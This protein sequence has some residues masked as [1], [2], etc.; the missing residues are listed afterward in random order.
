MLDVVP[1]TSDDLKKIDLR[2]WLESVES[3]WF[4][5]FMAGDRTAQAKQV[6]ERF[7]RLVESPGTSVY[8]AYE[9]QNLL[10]LAAFEILNW[11]TEYFG[12]PFARVAP[13]CAVSGLS[14]DELQSLYAS[15]L[16][17]AKG[18]SK[19]RNVRFLQRR[20]LSGRLEE[21]NA[22][23]DAGF[24]MVDNIVTM[25][26]DLGNTAEPTADCA[27]RDLKD[28]DPPILRAMMEDS[29]SHSRFNYVPALSDKGD[30]VYQRWFDTLVAD[31][32]KGVDLRFIVACDA[33]DSPLGFL[34]WRHATGLRRLLNLE[35]GLI[36]LFI[37][38]KAVRGRG[39]GLGL[40]QMAGRG[41]EAE[42]IEIAQTSTWINQKVAL[43][44]YQR[45]GYHVKEN[46]LTYYLDFETHN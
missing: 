46:L 6:A 11:D 29:F 38:D 23:E 16:D 15:V 24:R 4:V 18:W 40:L 1:I 42:G 20:L 33:N 22:L 9:G 19:E 43:F 5:D 2:Q 35:V 25:T 27:F 36:D 26:C 8:G 34:C 14:R 17:A 12:F 44:A 30:G 10:S 41:M 37:A 31:K 21:I 32:K 45:A 13:F 39:I 3:E 28:Q 7:E